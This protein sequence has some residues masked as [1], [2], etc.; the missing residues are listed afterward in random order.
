MMSSSGYA[1]KRGDDGTGAA[2]AGAAAMLMG[3]LVVVLAIVAI[4]I[5]ATRSARNHAGSTSN[6]AATSTMPWMASEWGCDWQRIA[7]EL[8][9][10]S[11]GERR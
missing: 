4:L 9:G 3:L 10:R 2:L 6:A 8:R 1:G 7:H 5:G 11:A